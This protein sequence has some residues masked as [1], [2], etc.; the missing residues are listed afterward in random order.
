M[1]GVTGLEPRLP[2]MTC[3]VV[4]TEP[5][6][7]T[8]QQLSRNHDRRDL[9]IRSAGVL[10]LGEGR[11]VPDV[12]SELEVSDKSVYKWAHA[13]NDR[14]LCGLLTGHKGGRPRALSDT[15]IAT[16]VEGARAE[17]M[18]L[19]QIALRVE[20]AH[21]KPLPCRLEMLSVAHGREGFPYKRGRYSLKKK[22]DEQ[23][24]AVKADTLS[25]LQQ[26]TRDGA[27]RLIYFDQSG[28][29]ASPPVQRGWSPIGEPYRVFSQPHCKRSVPG[30]FDF[31]A[32]LL[33]HEASKATIKRPAVVQFLEQIAQ[34]DP[35]GLMTVVVLDN[36]S[37][38]HNIDQ[39][40]I[41]RWFVEHRM[42]L[43]YL[44]P[45]SPEL[46]LSKSY[47]SMPSTTGDVS[48]LGRRKPSM[49]RSGS[50]SPVIDQNL[51]SVSPEH[52]KND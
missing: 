12:A 32:N 13:W 19:R 24:F 6:K 11:T 10:L 27:C 33:R 30:A 48:P 39:E 31:G 36:A 42:V 3:A 34:E 52:L 51:K 20:E 16:A 45:Y 5:E 2:A 38:H 14:G 47:E 37:I 44:P 35:P 18:T 4:L 28:F 49:L 41:D 50:C 25:K 23:E 22:R 7:K 8:L 17:S 1:L 26:A 29:S 40:M 21:G 46:N 9:R 43:F 15:L